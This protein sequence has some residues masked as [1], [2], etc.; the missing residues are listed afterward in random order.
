MLSR[1]YIN[2]GKELCNLIPAISREPVIGV[3]TEFMRNSKY[4]PVLSL[5]QISSSSSIYVIDALTI[6]DLTP[7]NHLFENPDQ[8]K[9]IHSSVNDLEVLEHSLSTKMS[10]VFD[11]QIAASFCSLQYQMGYDTLVSYFYSTVLDKKYQRCNWLSRPLSE[12]KI[13]YAGNDVLYL[14][15]LYHDMKKQLD[16]CGYYSYLE[17]ECRDIIENKPW[18]NFSKYIARSTKILCGAKTKEKLSLHNQDEFYDIV[19]IRK[20]MVIKDLLSLRE[21]V[22]IDN[23]VRRTLIMS[24]KNIV[25]IASL[26]SN[27]G[28]DKVHSVIRKILQNNRYMSDQTNCTKV[29]DIVL[30]DRAEA[31]QKKK[32]KMVILKNFAPKE[33]EYYEKLRTLLERVS[34]ESGISKELIS[35]REDMVKFIRFVVLGMGEIQ[36]IK[37]LNGWR[38]EVIGTKAL[39]RF[40]RVGL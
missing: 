20:A 11:T 39:E 21:R 34:K 5:I 28:R 31:V 27:K 23:N 14:I 22:A 2:N 16:A 8:I 12:D 35:T 30:M 32:E 40:G 9:V 15:Q 17:E 36:N 29:V 4:Y 33:K 24:D 37:I 25:D 10:S 18:N 38:K 19:K 13:L 3:D 6:R 1:C 7:L 26:R